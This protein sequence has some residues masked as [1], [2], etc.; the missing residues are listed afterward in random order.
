MSLAVP[1][2][3]G[4]HRNPPGEVTPMSTTLFAALGVL[5]PMHGFLRRLA[6][7]VPA[8]RRVTPVRQKPLSTPPPP[9]QAYC[10]RAR[11]TPRNRNR[12][13]MP[14]RVVRVLEAGQAAAPGGRMRISGRMADV[15]AELDRMA[16]WEA[17][18]QRA[19]A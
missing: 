6:A 9:E 14:L 13:N 4:S 18:L 11:A 17:S 5:A 16:E 8:V 10:A 19:G 3:R 12:V 7:V 2:P 15:C 1:I